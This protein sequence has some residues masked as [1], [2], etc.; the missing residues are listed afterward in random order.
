MKRER[1][2]R[3]QGVPDDGLERLDERRPQVRRR[4]HEHRHVRGLG[5]SAPRSPDH[6]VHRRAPLS[7]ELQR[8]DDV[9]GHPV[10]ARA[11]AD[12]E[13]EQGVL[14]AEP[15]R[16]Q[17]GPERALPAVVVRPRGELGDVVRRRV[18]L[19]LAQLAEVVDRMRGVTRAA[20]CP[21]HEQPATAVAE[22]RQSPCHGIDR[23][24]VKRR[25][26]LGDGCEVAVRVRAC[27]GAKSI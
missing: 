22:R 17:P 14:A 3:H 27:H 5:E 4:R 15:R 7:C 10:L 6:A 24:D 21:E 19:D 1:R 25:R 13:D 23:V 16:L 8:V 18:A 2:M 20:A 9:H 11:A 26:Q 12:R